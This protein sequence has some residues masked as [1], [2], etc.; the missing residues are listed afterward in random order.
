MLTILLKVFHELTKSLEHEWDTLVKK[1]GKRTADTLLIC[2]VLALVL[3]TFWFTLILS[4]FSLAY[5][6]K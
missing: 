6:F 4:L 2:M 3:E 1:I 5:F